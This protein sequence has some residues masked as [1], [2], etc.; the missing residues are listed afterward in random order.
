MGASRRTHRI[1]ALLRGE[2]ARLLLYEVS[3]PS[4]QGLLVT[5]VDLSPDLR[6]AKIYYTAPALD[7]KELRRGLQRVDGFLKKKLSESLDLRYVP[8]LE[9]IADTHTESVTSLMK[10]FEG[11]ESHP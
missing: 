11:L 5:D 6:Y 9:F 8:Q 1:A 3:D 10:A 4:V 7:P 2:L